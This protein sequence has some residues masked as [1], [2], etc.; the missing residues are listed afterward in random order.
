M[1]P[2]MVA[3]T[4][5]WFGVVGA[6]YATRQA[7]ALP[8]LLDLLFRP[9]AA[10]LTVGS[11][12]VLLWVAVDRVRPGAQA[13]V[14]IAGGLALDLFS[15]GSEVLLWN[16]VAVAFALGATAVVWGV[17]RWRESDAVWVGLGSGVLFAHV[18]DAATTGVGLAALGTVERNPIAASIIAIGD[19]AA[20]AHSG[21][22]A[23]LG[24]K[25]AVA[26]ATVSMLAG[27]AE[28]GRE[29]AALLVVAG[30]VGLAPAVHNLVLFSLTVS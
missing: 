9:P 7:V 14:T 22:A 6:A 29:E 2:A 8:R 12:V 18:L 11:V 28:S 5:P 25:I 21:I 3:S 17:Y 20:L 4:F 19:T 15:R 10:Y 27:S 13:P 30:G 24:V 26:L 1:T 16:G 23:F